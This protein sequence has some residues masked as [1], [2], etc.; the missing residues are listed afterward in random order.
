M[1]SIW[2]SIEI[3]PT[4]QRDGYLVEVKLKGEAWWIPKDYIMRVQQHVQRNRSNTPMGFRRSHLELP[5]RGPGF[6]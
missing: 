3:E 1:T 2:E 5:C 6:S 4:G